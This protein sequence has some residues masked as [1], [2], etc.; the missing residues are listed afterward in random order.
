MGVCIKLICPKKK[1][2]RALTENNINN[3]KLKKSLSLSQISKNNNQFQNELKVYSNLNNS[4]NIFI[5][6]IN[7]SNIQFSNHIIKRSNTSDKTLKINHLSTITKIKNSI[8]PKILKK[9]KNIKTQNIHSNLKDK[10][11]CFFCGGKECKSENYLTNKNLP[12]AIRGLNSNYITEK[13]I[14]GQ[15]PS[16]Y[17]INEYNLIEQFKKLNIGLIINLQK[18][19]EHPFCGPNA[20][21]LLNSGFSYNPSTFSGNDINVKFFGWKEIKSQLSINNI[22]YIVKEI[23]I[24]VLNKKQNVYIHS[25]SGNKRS[26]VIIAC[27]LIYTTNE[28]VN[29]VI[30]YIKEKRSSCLKSKNEKKQI[31]VFNNFIHVSRIIFGKKEKIDVYLKRQD[32]LLFGEEAEKFGY[33]PR[34]ITKTLEKILE[35]KFKYNLD[36]FFIMKFIK[37]LDHSW[38]NELEKILY[39]IKQKLNQNDWDIFYLNENL[40][41]FVELLFDFCEDSTY[42]II[43]PEKIDVLFNFALFSKFI[44]QN[45]YLFTDQQKINILSFVRKVLFAYEYS[46]IFQIS[47]F[48]ALFFDNNQNENYNILFHDMVN[49]FSIELLGYNLSYIQEVKNQ[50]T[51]DLIENRISSLSLIINFIVHEIVNPKTYLNEN[52]KINIFLFPTKSYYNFYVLY[53]KN[54][55]NTKRISSIETMTLTNLKN[56]SSNNLNESL[57]GLLINNGLNDEKKKI[58][59][60]FDKNNKFMKSE[61]KQIIFNTFSFNNSSKSLKDQMDIP[62]SKNQSSLLTFKYDINCCSFGSNQNSN[63][64]KLHCNQLY[65]PT[66]SLINDI[67]NFQGRKSCSYNGVIL[68]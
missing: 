40:S 2:K 42:Y 27:Y 9:K 30:K 12:N 26:S 56:S 43:N 67:H 59:K 48:C 22:L 31:K 44:N 45:N 52:N 3:K 18:E 20:N 6:N 34:I 53:S 65:S 19:G 7:T 63:K 41:I 5:E 57:N 38:N 24:F 50:S 61:N 15:R 58:K 54:K 39:L 62:L 47:S 46:I 13:I 21:K 28:A 29:D 36:N 51:I 33:V 14:I 25:H 4:S 16:D 66:S 35:I 11:I 49:R 8:N 64:L 1:G 17:L 60:A 10:L 37:G 55:E 23:S 32:D 68:K